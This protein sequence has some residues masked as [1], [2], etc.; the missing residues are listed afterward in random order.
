MLEV[1]LREQSQVMSLALFFSRSIGHG[2]IKR[3]TVAFSLGLPCISLA[4][5]DDSSP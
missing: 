1:F 3:T 5:Q 4:P 2:K